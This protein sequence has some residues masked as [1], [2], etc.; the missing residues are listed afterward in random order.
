MADDKAL[1][2][3][4]VGEYPRE[5]MCIYWL[6]LVGRLAVGGFC[7]P[8]TL[9][10]PAPFNWLAH[11]RPESLRRVLGRPSVVVSL[12]SRAQVGWVNAELVAARLHHPLPGFEHPACDLERVC[13]GGDSDSF[14]VRL[15]CELPVAHVGGTSPDPT[16]VGLIYL[17]PELRVRIGF[18][19]CHCAI[20]TFALSLQHATHYHLEIEW[21]RPRCQ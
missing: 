7:H 20:V 2:D 19:I 15:C 3:G 13:L 12:C 14:R 6:A 18:Y 4:S 21:V 16:S 17:G 11:A 8:A 10:L 9:P 5:T 1:G